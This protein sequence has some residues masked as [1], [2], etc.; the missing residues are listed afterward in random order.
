MLGIDPDDYGV[1]YRLAE[2]SKQNIVENGIRVYPNPANDEITIEFINYD[3]LQGAELQIYGLLGNLIFNKKLTDNISHV[4]VAELK[5]G[6]YFYNI[7]VNNNCIAKEKL[8][9]LK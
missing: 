1:S 8:V 5:S 2:P 7:V 4:S 6:L 3:N 9:I